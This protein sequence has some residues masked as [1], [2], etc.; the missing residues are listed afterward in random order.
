MLFAFPLNL[1]TDERIT[2]YLSHYF[3]GIFYSYFQIAFIMATHLQQFKASENKFITKIVY[4]IRV[5]KSS[6]I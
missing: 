6:I 1:S 5:L 2:K 4:V 3:V